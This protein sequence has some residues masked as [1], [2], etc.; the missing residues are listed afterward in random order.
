MQ[1]RSAIISEHYV[2][3][4]PLFTLS[5]TFFLGGQE[6][7]SKPSLSDLGGGFFFSKNHR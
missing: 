4:P 6:R 1:V 3:P 5:V 2:K 7:K